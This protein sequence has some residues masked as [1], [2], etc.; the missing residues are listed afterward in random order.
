[1]G[2]IGVASLGLVGGAT[3][4]EVRGKIVGADGLRPAAYASASAERH[5]FTVREF[6]PLVPQKFAEIGADPDRDVTLAVYAAG[7]KTGFMP[8]YVVRLAGARATPS[9][10]VVPPGVPIL[11]RNDDP[12]THK[13]VGEGWVR[14][15][16]P[17][18]T[19]QFEPKGKGATAVTDAL[20]PSLHA[21]I[22]VD[23]G[24]VA[25][26][27]AA[28]DGTLKIDLPAGEVVLKAYFEGKEKASV[29]L[30]V[31][32]AGAYEIKDP[33]VVGPVPSASAKSPG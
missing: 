30:K 12:F 16:P 3:A 9:T 26:R 18:A 20:V 1:L 22:V 24:V 2:A 25:D 29:G 23:D 27:F 32:T 7:D 17:G 8:A 11:F 28:H 4:G 6:D 15:L 19:H 21:W 33:I 5:A 13:L 10:A 31:P 14:E